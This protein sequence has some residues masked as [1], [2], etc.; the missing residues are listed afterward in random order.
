MSS[1]GVVA[2]PA[3]ALADPDDS[4][5]AR[6][7]FRRVSA[8]LIPFLFVLYIFNYIDRTNIAIAALQMNGDLHLS[9]AAYGLGAGVFCLGYA[10]FE[11]PSNLALA[12]V[13]ARRWIARIMITW[14]LIASAM[15]LVRSPMQFY[16]ARFLLGVAEAGFSPGV[17]YYLSEWVPATQRGRTMAG[18]MTAIP[19]SATLGGPL[20]G[21][22]LGFNCALGL[23]GWQWLFLVE[24]IPS[25][26]LRTF[27]STPNVS[28]ESCFAPCP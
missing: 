13:G 9:A 23:R 12:R 4:E 27:A 22:L 15:M 21:W 1:A 8:R 10:L 14:G 2:A 6:A 7:T 17:L 24:G 25:V 20:G 26:L 3:G 11:I 28:Q 5:L 16:V 18:F 19:L